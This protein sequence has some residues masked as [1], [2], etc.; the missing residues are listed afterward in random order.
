ME[1]NTL[2]PFKELIILTMKETNQ[3]V[4]IYKNGLALENALGLNLVNFERYRCQ[5]KNKSP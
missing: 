5:V 1:Q 3:N 4:E 2:L